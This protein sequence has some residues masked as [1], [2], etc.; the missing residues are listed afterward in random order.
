MRHLKYT[1][2][3]NRQGPSGLISYSDCSIFHIKGNV[4]GMAVMILMVVGFS[5]HVHNGRGNRQHRRIL[6]LN[7]LVIPLPNSKLCSCCPGYIKTREIRMYDGASFTLAPFLFLEVFLWI[8]HYTWKSILY[9]T[10]ISNK[11]QI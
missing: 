11:E 3:T 1:F 6:I 8:M 5:S 9:I 7:E 2:V 4:V 10:I